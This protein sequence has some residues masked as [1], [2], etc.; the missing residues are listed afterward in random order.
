[1]S[2][3]VDK[4]ICLSDLQK[5]VLKGRGVFLHHVHGISGNE[6]HPEQTPVIMG[7]F[8]L[9][10]LVEK[11]DRSIKMYPSSDCK[12]NTFTVFLSLKLSHSFSLITQCILSVDLC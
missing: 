3:T 12:G 7:V 6:T 2:G 9:H 5:E 4:E 11:Q 8:F 10:H 1:M